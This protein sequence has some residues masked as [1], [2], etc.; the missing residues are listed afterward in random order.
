MVRYQNLGGD[1]GVLAFEIGEDHIRVQ[2]QDYAVYEYTYNS[3]G[4]AHIE[5]MK[6]L[7]IQGKGLNSYINKQVRKKYSRKIQ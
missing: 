1:S 2:F 4:R 3:A 5:N 7:A 6:T